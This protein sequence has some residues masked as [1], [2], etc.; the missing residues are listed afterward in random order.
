M[1]SS[2]LPPLFTLT[3]LGVRPRLERTCFWWAS[4]NYWICVENVWCVSYLKSC[5]TI[6]FD[7]YLYWFAKYWSLWRNISEVSW[8][9]IGDGGRLVC[10]EGGLETCLQSMLQLVF[11]RSRVFTPERC[12]H[13]KDWCSKQKAKKDILMTARCP[14]LDSD[15]PW[16]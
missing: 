11:N 8:A 14:N 10:S 6:F 15:K 3:L 13:S 12:L 9:R 4:C 1:R 2:Y 16:S 5:V 7:I